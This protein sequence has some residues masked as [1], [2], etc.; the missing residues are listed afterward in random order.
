MPPKTTGEITI[1]NKHQEKRRFLHSS[2]VYL[3][4]NGKKRLHSFFNKNVTAQLDLYQPIPPVSQMDYAVAL[5]SAFVKIM[6]QFAVQA[7]CV[8]AQVSAKAIASP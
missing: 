2:Q 4:C 6:V 1:C 5:Q 8:R 7:L 3:V